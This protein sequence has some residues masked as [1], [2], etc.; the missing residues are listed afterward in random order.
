MEN[1]PQS[2]REIEELIEQLLAEIVADPEVQ[3]E[4]LKIQPIDVERN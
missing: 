2:D 3:R 1:K 4:M